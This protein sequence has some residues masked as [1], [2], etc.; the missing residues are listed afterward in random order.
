VNNRQ[1]E[2]LRNVLISFIAIFI[3]MQRAE[4]RREMRVKDSAR[5][6]TA[7]MEKWFW[8]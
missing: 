1:T 6:L 8:F 5:N 7:L 4:E 3:L 2:K